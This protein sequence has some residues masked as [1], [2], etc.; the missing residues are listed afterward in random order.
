[1]QKYTVSASISEIMFRL[2]YESDKKLVSDG[3]ST[4]CHRDRD[5]ATRLRY[6]RF[7]NL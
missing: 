7:W 6:C 2:L 5:R 1:V 3:L 4:V